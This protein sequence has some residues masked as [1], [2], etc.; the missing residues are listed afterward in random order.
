MPFDLE[1]FERAKF[2]PRRKVVA[3]ESLAAFFAE[4]EAPEWEVRGLTANELHRAMEAS[5]RQ[6]NMEA[7]VKAMTTNAEQVS[8]MRKALGLTTDTPGEIAKR[9][10]MLVM[11]SVSPAIELPVAVKLA[12]AFPVEFLMLTNE[13]TEL[14]GKGAEMG[15]PAAASQPT[16]A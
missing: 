7:I 9:L 14:T 12:E 1:R 2:E 10:E 16:P 11:G 6:G 3:V 15:K 13:I 5:R 8:T 4:G